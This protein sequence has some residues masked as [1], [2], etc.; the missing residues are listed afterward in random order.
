L[1]TV[2]SSASQSSKQ[3][4]RERVWDLLEARRAGRE[5]GIHGRIPDFIGSASAAAQLA[6]LP[7]WEN[8]QVVKAVPDSA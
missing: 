7:A 5:P 8:A 1:T 6:S 4:V 3:A 2:P